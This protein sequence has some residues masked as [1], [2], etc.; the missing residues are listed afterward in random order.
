VTS[1]VNLLLLLLL[2][3]KADTSNIRVEQSRVACALT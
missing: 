3:T 2:R 1:L